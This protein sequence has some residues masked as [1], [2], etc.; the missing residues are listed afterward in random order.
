MNRSSGASRASLAKIGYVRSDALGAP[1]KREE[2]VQTPPL[3][4][5]NKRGVI[6]DDDEHVWR[7]LAW[8]SRRASIGRKIRQQASEFGRS[9]IGV[10]GE[11]DK[12]R[13]PAYVYAHDRNAPG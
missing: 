6:L 8:R 10:V 7:V 2:A 3:S 11:Q 5:E 13:S 9:R 4:I 1:R 12:P